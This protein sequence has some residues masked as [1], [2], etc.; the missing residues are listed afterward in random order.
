MKATR[1]PD[2]PILTPASGDIGDNINGPSVIRVPDWV[3][4]PRGRYY[5]YFAHHQGDSIRLATA[6]HPEGP[7]TVQGQRPLRL[8]QVTDLGFHAHIASPD[9]VIDR[10]HRRFL[11]FFHGPTRA[12]QAAGTPT[13][14]THFSQGT[15]L[16]LS[17]DGVD[18]A[19]VV[20]PVLGFPYFRVF[21]HRG[22]AYALS[23][24]GLL[25]R[26]PEPG[27]PDG[28]RPWEEREQALGFW[29]HCA[30]RMQGDGLQVVFSRPGDAP[31]RL[32]WAEAALGD[33]WLQWR[34]GEPRE[35]LR[36]ELPWEGAGL[37]I[38][39][40]VKGAARG[41][42]HALRDPCLFTEDGQSWLY[43]SIGGESGLAVARLI[44]TPARTPVP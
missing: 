19:P 21:F 12:W 41:R 31:E 1:C 5:L 20:G 43:N 15:G 39:T 24:R 16:A 38:T 10:E 4:H 3:R 36:P 14:R 30:V 29:R 37:P 6:D 33:D 11:M 17:T 7:W 9:V 40:S 44:E 32:L 35:L 25:F 34:L 22:R 18:F 27:M 2:N 26:C 23:A 42:E 8:E 28:L 13:L